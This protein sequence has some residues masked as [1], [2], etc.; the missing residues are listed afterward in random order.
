MP[1]V[2]PAVVHFP[3]AS[4]GVT[5]R[6][7]GRR[8]YHFLPAQERQRERPSR[9]MKERRVL[10]AQNRERSRVSCSS[11]VHSSRVESAE[12]VQQSL[13]CFLYSFTA[14]L[15]TA[16]PGWAT[17]IT[18]PS[19]AHCLQ[20]CH[21][22]SFCFHRFS[23]P[24][25]HS[26][27]PL[28]PSATGAAALYFPC[29][30]FSHSSHCSPP[31][32]PPRHSLLR[33]LIPLHLVG[34]GQSPAVL[35]RHALLF[36]HN[37]FIPSLLT[38]L[39]TAPKSFPQTPL[40]LLAEA[41][42]LV[43]EGGHPQRFLRES[44]E[45]AELACRRAL[46]NLDSIESSYFTLMMPPPPSP[47]SSSVRSPSRCPST[48]PGGSGS[49]AQDE[50]MNAY[51]HLVQAHEAQEREAWSLI[52]ISP[53]Y[54][55]WMF[56]LQAAAAYYASIFSIPGSSSSTSSTSAHASC[57]EI[58][59]MAVQ[60]VIAGDL[61]RDSLLSETVLQWEECQVKRL[62]EEEEKAQADEVSWQNKILVW[63]SLR[64]W[65]RSMRVW[66]RKYLGKNKSP[67]TGEKKKCF[68][69]SLLHTIRN[70]L[71]FPRAP[72]RALENAT[73]SS[74]I[75]SR[76]S[77]GPSS[78]RLEDRGKKGNEKEG[79]PPSLDSC[80]PPRALRDEQPSSPI[81]QYA[82]DTPILS[83][84]FGDSFCSASAPGW[85]RDGAA[86][87]TGETSTNEDDARQE[88]E[89]LWKYPYDKEEDVVVRELLLLERDCFG[90]SRFDARGEHRHL[91][92]VLHLEDVGKTWSSAAV[93]FHPVVR[94]FGGFQLGCSS[95]ANGRWIRFQLSC[96]SDAEDDHRL[97]ARVCHPS[98]ND[99]VGHG[100]D[101]AAPS[102]STEVMEECSK[103]SRK[104][105]DQ[106]S[107]LN[108]DGKVGSKSA[109]PSAVSLIPLFEEIR[110]YDE[111]NLS[112][113]PETSLS[114]SKSAV[115]RN[116]TR[117]PIIF[118][119][120]YNDSICPIRITATPKERKRNL[121]HTEVFELAVRQQQEGQ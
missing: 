34:T 32:P 19:L 37:V 15:A 65:K 112:L 1:R 76:H 70:G 95:I 5:R 121:L 24:Y 27:F 114:C 30:S 56:E 4:R 97:V 28:S 8:V 48:K 31:P 108:P 80:S 104:G 23:Y 88:E 35:L 6:M 107:S 96:E 110:T 116:G 62:Y 75:F 58:A 115:A 25:T 106:A 103:E 98:P 119:V 47:S 22:R 82:R 9:G 89:S 63:F 109:S 10:A 81:Y 83:T 101:G 26:I 79:T 3:S 42:Q 46:L 69:F 40:V 66:G 43:L 118:S 102:S 93:L 50:E 91:F 54:R 29:R 84:L 71:M 111:D 59:A 44:F 53:L 90:S 41:F 38:T 51:Y 99:G 57:Y 68:V 73:S 94:A 61:R 78:L 113:S 100:D 77:W 13:S 7:V 21:H 72:T 36:R 60:H 2:W 86:D 11:S 87:G 74:L 105:E 18:S 67:Y 120:H 14:A 49:S 16:S 85:S 17:P 55:L 39:G 20:R 52:N 45:R 64:E 117:A 12:V 92:H 33:H